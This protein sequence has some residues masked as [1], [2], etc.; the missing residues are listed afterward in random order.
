MI[1]VSSIIF[2]LWCSASSACIPQPVEI[3]FSKIKKVVLLEANLYR[4]ILLKT[5]SKLSYKES[6]NVKLEKAMGNMLWGSKGYYL[7]TQKE[8]EY[9]IK[10]SD[11][12]KSITINFVIKR[13]PKTKSR[14]VEGM[15]KAQAFSSNGGCGGK[16]KLKYD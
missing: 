16:F 7:N 15:K 1:K 12:D 11:G 13:A 4:P 10:L 6:E 3:D 8:G 5:D 2:L 9:D 14:S